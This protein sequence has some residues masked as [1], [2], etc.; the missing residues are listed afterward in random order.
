MRAW[1]SV[2]FVVLLA[3]PAA[4]QRGAAPPSSDSALVEVDPIRCWWRT[5]KGAIAL[6]EVFDVR[7]TCAVLETDSVQVV[8]DESRLTAAGVQLAPFEVVGGD[9]PGDSREGRR[10]FFQYRYSLRLLDAAQ[11]GQDVS[12]PNLPIIYNVQT[13]VAEDARLAGRD[14]TYVMPGLPVRVL[15]LVPQ[16]G[17]D[18]RDGAD[19]GLERIDAL[20]FRARLFDI[21]AV[22]LSAAGLLAGALALAAIVGRARPSRTRERTRPSERRAL[23]A[24]EAE[25][26]RMARASMSEGWTPE[27]AADAHAALRV[28]GAVAAGQPL[29]DQALPRGEAP[30]DGRIAIRD[31]L[32]WRT[33]AAISGSATA[34]DVSRALESLPASASPVDRDG[35]ESLR[36][37]LAAVTAARFGPGEGSLDGGARRPRSRPVAPRPRLGRAGRWR[38][39]SVAATRRPWPRRGG[40]PTD[41]HPRVARRRHRRRLVR[42]RPRGAHLLAPGHRARPRSASRRWPSCCSGCGWRGRVG[43]G[44]GGSWSRPCWP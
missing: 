3:L 20:R 8:A 16:G 35:L 10:R 24:A 42:P 13:Q 1:T 41:E 9:R 21:G 25:L 15:S 40:A 12:L 5:S 39:A 2:V 26:D 18:I 34:S 11:V 19:V 7:L 14:F 31:P 28:V 38:G 17:V 37:A 33:G 23:A 6:G 36:A 32:P 22:A 27:R 29:G 43:P 30:A 44:A 4:A